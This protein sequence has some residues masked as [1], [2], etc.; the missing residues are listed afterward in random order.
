[1]PKVTVS[2]KGTQIIDGEED[3][4]EFMSS[5]E[6]S[7]DADGI[8]LKYFD[9]VSMG[10]ENVETELNIC[11]GA[12]TLTRNKGKLG[13]L[14]IEENQRHLCPYYTPYGDFTIGISGD[15]V[16]NRLMNG[17]ILILKYTIDLNS[18][19]MSNNIVEIT[20]GEEK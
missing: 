13:Q 11:G 5:G 19:L 12:V 9:S 1:M 18:Q 15:K 6:M 4:T 16:D 10:I 20:V 14:I 17:G 3:V 8:T 2:I 7:V